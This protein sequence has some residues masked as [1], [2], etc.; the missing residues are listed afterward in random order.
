MRKAIPSLLAA[1]CALLLGCGADRAPANRSSST[2]DPTTVPGRVALELWQLREGVSLGRWFTDHA[3]ERI[4]PFR[5]DTLSAFGL[6]CAR[7]EWRAAVAGRELVRQAVFYPPEP[8]A[9]LEL[10]P[11]SI[12]EQLVAEGCA[13]GMVWLEVA[14]DSAAAGP[15][16]DSVR[17]QLAALLGPADTSGAPGT[18]ASAFWKGAVQFARGELKAVLALEAFPHLGGQVAGG[19]A[20]VVALAY[21]PA[22]A[23]VLER[24]DADAAL[25]DTLPLAR[26]AELSGLDS[27]L[28][29]QLLSALE[30][31]PFP[32][33]AESSPLG[34]ALR[35]WLT[36][37]Q[38]LSAPRRA[39]A[40]FV[41]D[42]A[43]A[44]AMCAHRLCGA[45]DSVRRRP[46]EALGA[47]F[48]FSPLAGGWIYERT[49]L[50]L[51]RFLDRDSEVGQAVLLQQLESGF[52]FSGLCA[53]GREGFRR[54][55]DN[56]ERYLARVPN[57]PIA[58]AVRVHVARAYADVVALARG[59]LGGSA[60]SL[61]YQLEAPAA[62]LKAIEHY[63]LAMAQAPGA[64][65]ARTA[66]R[67]AWWVLAGLRPERVRF[68]CPYG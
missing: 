66:W 22:A 27:G 68:Y 4:E 12:P 39:A 26:A 17:F 28:W 19:R 43:L 49:W 55:I 64:A 1:P 23:R 31:S 38:S 62:R 59:A 11:D 29:A 9:G 40:L 37:A 35:S 15:L 50:N 18:F 36:A 33:P 61:D 21:L 10:P 34:D 8:P 3:G 16:L 30:R 65:A 24:R 53:R 51:A 7:A 20:R 67:E 54:V 42:Q 41:A 60:D 25:A 13:L 14:A 45:Q 44:R 47:R 52:D 5:P 63:R 32:A 6:W 46:L 48:A 58:A 56:G 2:I 57:S